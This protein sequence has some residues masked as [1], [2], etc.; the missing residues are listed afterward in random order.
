MQT[1]DYRVRL[2]AFEG[3][4]DL[5]LFLVR[6]AEVEIADIPIATI[7]DQYVEFV[8]GAQR[9]AGP[10]G[11]DIDTAGEF[12]VMAAT[13]AEIKSR[14]IS[15]VGRGGGER[16][17]VAAGG[18]GEDPRAELVRQLLAYKQYR[19]A[20]DELRRR[21]EEWQG[22]F[23]SAAVPAPE[24][25]A[26]EGEA[27]I[28]PDPGVPE[29]LELDLL[30]VVEAFRKIAR[31]V[32]FGALGAHSVTYDDTPIEEHAADILDRLRRDAD[33][34]GAMPLRAIFA[35]RTRAEM[36]GLFLATLEL[37]RRRELVVK[38]DRLDGHVYVAAGGGTS[39]APGEAPTGA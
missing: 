34:D 9:D 33:A 26:G 5:L 27:E 38:Q 6:K 1:S 14:S 7:A 21:F 17:G 22:R 25:G 31:T 24:P 39:P 20:G 13:L 18:G 8:R 3:P 2:D 4:L 35:G 29:D 11:I 15:E 10:A 23:P 32:D 37:V 16:G 19:D 30:D 12:L 28:A 36:I